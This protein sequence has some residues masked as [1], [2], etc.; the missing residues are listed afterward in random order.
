MYGTRGQV[1]IEVM[2][3][4]GLLIIGSLMLATF[5]TDLRPLAKHGPEELRALFLA[6]EGIEAARAMRDNDFNLLTDGPHGLAFGT[7]TWSFIGTSDTTDGL[8]RQV[9]TAW[10]DIRTKKITSTVT[11]A[12]TSAILTTALLDTDHDLGMAHFVAFDLSGTSASLS[13]GNKQL[14]GMIIKNIGPLPITVDKVTA[15]WGDNSLIQSVKLGTIVWAHNNIGT[16]IGKQSSGTELN[17]NDFTL[18]GGQ[19]ESNTNL[20]FQGPVNTVNFI[21]KFTFTDGSSAYV[22]IQP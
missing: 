21:V 15:W 1:L 4:L 16:P 12:K 17:I 13:N 19:S 22:T 3:S 18:V 2:V 20:T 5:A 14:N 8:I 6:K 9:T 11:G 7:S 10:L